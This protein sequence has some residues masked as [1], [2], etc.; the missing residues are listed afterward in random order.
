MLRF[1]TNN[2]EFNEF[3]LF[4]FDMDG[5]LYDE[6][7]FIRQAYAPV[8]KYIAGADETKYKRIYIYLLDTWIEYGS[9]KTDTF[10]L[11]FREAGR[12]E[13]RGEIKQCVELFR[14]CDI[15]ITLPERTKH[16]LNMIVR[17]GKELILITDG[18][19][20]LQR[21]KIEALGL[22]TWFP[23]NRIFISGDYGKEYQKPGIKILEKINEKTELDNKQVCYFGDRLVDKRFADAAGFAFHFVPCMQISEERN[24]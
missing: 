20:V 24:P 17:S 1:S 23:D 6:F 16:I 2:A 14:N 19:S 11:A 12:I 18:N 3:D 4:A 13:E 9:S 8:A 10:Q 5:T 7:D 21:R 15:A 22:N